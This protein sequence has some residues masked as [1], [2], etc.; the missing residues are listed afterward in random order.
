VLDLTCQLS[1]PGEYR[2]EVSLY[3]KEAPTHAL[4]REFSIQSLG[5]VP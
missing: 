5:D 3:F 4:E 2:F 1:E